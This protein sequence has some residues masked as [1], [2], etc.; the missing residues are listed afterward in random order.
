MPRRARTRRARPRTRG[1][2]GSV[3]LERAQPLRLLAQEALRA[4]RL[5]IR[6]HVRRRAL[7]VAA[8][9]RRH[10]RELQDQLA[11]ELGVVRAQPQ[12]L[13]GARRLRP[14]ALRSHLLLLAGVAALAAAA[15]ERLA[16]QLRVLLHVGLVDRRRLLALLVLLLAGLR[17][18]Q[19]RLLAEHPRAD[20]V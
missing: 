17:V 15:P 13:V 1:A 9:A 6:R 16:Q 2:A 19:D 4:R 8:D 14:P 18:L 10:R 3:G 7:A 20:A 11:A 5:A 12:P